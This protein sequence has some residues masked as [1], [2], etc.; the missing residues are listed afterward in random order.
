MLC[1][2]FGVSEKYSKYGKNL[3]RENLLPI[4]VCKCACST[5]CKSN[6][7]HFNI[8]CWSCWFD[9]RYH[10]RIGICFAFHI[11]YYFSHPSSIW[12]ANM[13]PKSK[14]RLFT[15]V[16]HLKTL[17]WKRIVSTRNLFNSDVFEFQKIF[18]PLTHIACIIILNV[19]GIESLP[20]VLIWIYQQ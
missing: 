11:P 5:I 19:T 9:H 14:P 16:Y 1:S 15:K 10:H 17:L 6:I 4:H 12:Y 2:A 8:G 3:K 18:P 20:K 13:E 7:A